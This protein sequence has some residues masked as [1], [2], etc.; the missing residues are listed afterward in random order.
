MNATLNTALISRMTGGLWQDESEKS[1]PIK[2]KSASF[3][4]YRQVPEQEQEEQESKDIS[5][6][7]SK[8]NNFIKEYYIEINPNTGKL[9][10]F[11]EYLHELITEARNDLRRGN[12]F[13]KDTQLEFLSELESYLTIWQGM[14]TQLSS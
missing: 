12:Y 10:T 7:V 14:K 9:Q 11:E 8:I 3:L 6:P 4:F 5:E 13:D 1:A 2:E